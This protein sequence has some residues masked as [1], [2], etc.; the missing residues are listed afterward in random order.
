MAIPLSKKKYWIF[1]LVLAIV[2]SILCAVA[3]SRY[4]AGVSSDST[5]YL[6]VAQNFLAGN[7]LYDHRGLPLLSWPPL[8][9]LVLAGLNFLTGVDVFVAG[10]YFNVFLFGL[11]VFLSGVIFYRVFSYQPL[12]AYL[13]CLFAFL[14]LSSLRMHAT[15]SSDP[16]YLTLTLGFLIAV[17][18]YI[19]RRSYRAYVWMVLF[20]MLAP[21]LR[22]VGLAVT[23][24]AG[25]VIL[26]ENRKTFRIFL[27]DGFVLGILSILPIAWWLLVH[28]VMTHGSLW[29]L[30]SQPV[31]VGE[32]ISLALTKTL[33]WFVPY[34][35]FLMP[36]L[37]RPWIP[38]GLLVL[39]LF[40]LNWK[41]AEYGRSW[42][43]SLAAP[44]V[45]PTMIYALVY[46]VALALTVVTQDHRD[47]FSDR[48]Y[49][50]LLVPA[51]ILILLTFDRLILP[52]LKVSTR[53]LQAALILLFV[54]WSAYPVYS[55]NEYLMEA[56]QQGEPSGANMFNNR[57]YREM[58]VVTQMLQISAQ[59]PQ[60]RLY[61]N[62]VDAVWFYT[63]KPV[64][65]LPFV[66]DDA[67]TVYAGWPHDRPGYIIWFEPNEYKHYLAPQKIAEFADIELV[68]EGKGGQIYYVQSR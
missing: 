4:G 24:T 48:Y 22:Y 44:S 55:A 37:L 19:Q 38:L 53:K 47:L 17:D 15:I 25:L 6:S 68:Y 1:L 50:I 2:A 62:Y 66:H 39:I 31:D 21:M 20:S 54:I 9:P 49:V 45:Y 58:P 56:I 11:N 32:N 43:R 57:F 52:H 23:V 30:S 28:N 10:W 3:T 36:V 35:S 61:S 26:I 51:A 8:Y 46:F 29:G 65:L 5:K 63:R 13:A 41:R 42:V 27:R 14:S 12:Y 67:P 64:S 59:Q 18:G 40:L 7:G 16:F 33:H 34:V 60:E